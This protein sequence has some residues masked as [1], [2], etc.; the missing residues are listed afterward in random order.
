MNLGTLIGWI[1]GLWLGLGLFYWVT[2][3]NQ[4]RGP[5]TFYLS[6][7]VCVVFALIGAIVGTLLY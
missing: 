1:V 6:F 4:S 3:K 7:P 2:R 5:E